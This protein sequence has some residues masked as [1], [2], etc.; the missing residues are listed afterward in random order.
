MKL[1]G[2]SDYEIFPETGKVWSYK[3]NK[4]IGNIGTKGYMQVSL[5]DDNGKQHFW[6]M[7]RLI[8][9]VVNGEIPDDLTV[10][11]IN[12]DKLNN[13]ISNLNLMTNA[14]QN[15]WGTRL[16]RFAKSKSLYVVAIFNGDIKMFLPSI[17]T[18]KEF[19][20]DSTNIVRCCKKQQTTHK[21]YQWMYLDDYL[22]DWWEQEME[23]VL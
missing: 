21:G 3:R 1:K 19:N 20:F 14:E 5:R 11:H 8:W 22:A 10:N 16:K 17:K 23:R 2:Y 4:Y 13:S 9:T 7:H 15:V 18:A 6:Q 12:E